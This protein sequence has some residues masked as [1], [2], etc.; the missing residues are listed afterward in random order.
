[1]EDAGKSLIAATSSSRFTQPNYWVDKS[2][3]TAYQ[4]QVQVPEYIMNDPGQ[5]DNILLSSKNGK[6]VYMRDAATWKME[7]VEGEYDRLNQKRFITITANL[8]R[9]TV[10]TAIDD[11][12][13]IIVGMGKL[14]E[15]IKIQQPGQAEVFGQTFQELQQG[16]LLAIVVI[17]L[18]L[19]VNFQSFKL[20]LVVVSIIPGIIAGSFLLLWICGKT[21][22]IQSYMGCIMAIGV[23]VANA[24]LF[25][26]QAEKHR[27]EKLKDPYLMGI[28]D[29]IRPIV[30]TSFAMIAGM[31]P[32]VLGIGEGGDQTSPLGTAVIG[33]LLFSMFSS[34]ILLPLV[35]QSSIGNR[36]SP[37]ISLDPDDPHG[38]YHTQTENQS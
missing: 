21:L 35:Y 8:H 4:V 29:R 1:V 2:T 7:N 10:G 16:I 37:I 32:M 28:K 3:G 9:K 30:M 19:A 38:K 20:S 5:V 12:D 11:I 6:Q 31:V 23:A 13:K 26:T 33:G 18:M 24:I 15:G 17:F 25:V 22:N 14:P 36:P 34:L 27:R